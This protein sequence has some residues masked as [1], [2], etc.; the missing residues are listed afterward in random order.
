[1]ISPTNPL[2]V[3]SDDL[4]KEIYRVTKEFPK[5]EMYGMTSQIR[6]AGLSVVLNIIEGFARQGENEYRRFLVIA[7]GSLKETRYLLQFAFEQ[8]YIVTHDFKRLFSLSD[9]VGKI[10]WTIIQN[11]RNKV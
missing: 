5:N 10:L 1:M 8:Q 9:E 11:T 4:A 3:K 6:R 7:F 2:Y